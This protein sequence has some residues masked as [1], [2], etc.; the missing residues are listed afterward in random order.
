MFVKSELRGC[1]VEV[2]KRSSRIASTSALA[3]ASC[4]DQHDKVRAAAATLSFNFNN[5]Q[6]PKKHFIQSEPAATNLTHLYLNP[7]DQ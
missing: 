1:G 5:H 7:K 6:Q 2:N 3:S 4:R